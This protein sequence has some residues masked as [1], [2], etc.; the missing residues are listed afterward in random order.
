ML[1]DIGRRFLFLLGSIIVYRI[2]ASI[3]LPF[4]NMKL[5]GGASLFGEDS[6]LR[7]FTRFAGGSIENASI[8]ALGVS[9]Y[10]GASIACQVLFS[11]FPYFVELKKEE[12]QAIVSRYTRYLSILISIIQSM[13][14]VHTLYMAQTLTPTSKF[15]T[16][17]SR[18]LFYICGCVSLVAASF[19]LIW[20]GEQITEYG[21][22]NGVS[23][24]ITCDI[25]SRL[26]KEIYAIYQSAV[27]GTITRSA[28]LTFFLILILMI[29]FIIFIEQGQRQITLQY[30]QRQHGNKIY[31]ANQTFLPLKIN[32]SGVTPP[33]FAFNIMFFFNLIKQQIILR[34]GI[35]FSMLTLPF[36]LSNFDRFLLI[37]LIIAMSYLYT[38][39]VVFNTEEIAQSLQ[40]PMAIIPG[41]RP[42]VDTSKYLDYV[43][44]R[45]TLVGS[46]YIIFI[47]F[48]PEII[49]KYLLGGIQTRF[50]G[51]SLL[52][53]VVVILEIIAKIQ[54]QILSDRYKSLLKNT[55][56]NI[57]I[58]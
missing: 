40:K 55:K 14:V 11:V 51:T 24:I 37:I 52:I 34:T 29:F 48:L 2:G 19:F 45:L 13:S 16:T 15:I 26:P 6:L 5:A 20:L 46:F 23:V 44:Q 56:E 25:L 36:I 43:M 41:I 9:P 18:I 8:F 58:I 7:L 33:I 54:T 21:L 10:I 50:I 39:A 42:G 12:G 53:V 27:S 32:M 47:S 38:F 17:D 4:V 22:G 3:T 49:S 57:K 28:A 30:P 1:G 35:D 31:M